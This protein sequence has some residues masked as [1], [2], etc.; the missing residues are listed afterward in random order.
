[1]AKGGLGSCGV[2]GLGLRGSR[3]SSYRWFPLWRPAAF[4]CPL[5]RRRKRSPPGQAERSVDQILQDVTLRTPPLSVVAG[6]RAAF[7]V[8]RRVVCPPTQPFLQLLRRLSLSGPLE[9]G[10]PRHLW[11]PPS[12]LG[13]GASPGA[14][15]RLLV[16][17]SE[18]Y[19][20]VVTSI[21]QQLRLSGRGSAATALGEAEATK[22]V[23]LR[24]KRRTA[25]T[26][27]LKGT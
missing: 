14:G 8:G 16:V 9:D 15:V 3:G 7:L 26:T 4:Y 12:R 18:R 20:V 13:R 5:L 1:M 11:S 24:R 2:A 19:P 27:G 22:E 17:R 25:E 10:E 23:D 21:S 6:R